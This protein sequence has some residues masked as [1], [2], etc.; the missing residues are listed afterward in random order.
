M[1]LVVLLAPSVA[2]DARYFERLTGDDDPIILRAES[3]PDVGQAR[4]H[5]TFD[6]DT[7]GSTIKA[8]PRRR[9]DRV[10]WFVN[11]SPEEQFRA[12]C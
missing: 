7:T 12:A 2:R 10:A 11:R 8:R 4:A 3:A 1:A 5:E 6:P 9:C